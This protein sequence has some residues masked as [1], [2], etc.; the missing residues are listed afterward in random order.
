MKGYLIEK[1][2]FSLVVTI[3][4]FLSFALLWI[5]IVGMILNMLAG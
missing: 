2:L 5:F 1:I 3:A 4:A